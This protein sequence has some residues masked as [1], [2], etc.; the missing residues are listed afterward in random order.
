MGYYTRYSLDQMGVALLPREFSTLIEEDEG[1]RQAL[2]PDGETRK[3]QKWYE[4]EE[5]VCAWSARFPGTI[6]RL[7]AEGEDSDGIWDKYFLNGKLLHTE[8]FMGLPSINP[9]ELL[10]R[11]L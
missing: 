6:F 1:A 4:H 3:A 7:H 5:C 11:R 10:N 9:D 8:R 2:H